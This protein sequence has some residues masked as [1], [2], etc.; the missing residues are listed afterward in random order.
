MKRICQTRETIARA[1]RPRMFIECLIFAPQLAPKNQKLPR[2]VRKTRQLL[3]NLHR[4]CPTK[5]GLGVCRGLQN[6][7]FQKAL[8]EFKRSNSMYC[9]QDRASSAW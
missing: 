3:R 8:D 9:E 5:K 1:A 6:Q 7:K 4:I 2:R